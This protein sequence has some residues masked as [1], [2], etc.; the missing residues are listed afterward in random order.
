MQVT[1]H[2][3]PGGHVMSSPHFADSTHVNVQT[4]PLHVPPAAAHFAL[5]E[6]G[7]GDPEEDD[8]DASGEGAGVELV[9][10]SGGTTRATVGLSM[11]PCNATANVKV[12]AMQTRIRP[13]DSDTGHHD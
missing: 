5:Q 7:A 2:G 13:G 10:A 11:H 9:P 8:A 3:I 1:L 4:S 6:G 12:K